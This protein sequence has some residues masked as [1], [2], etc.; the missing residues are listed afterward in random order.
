VGDS[1]NPIVDAIRRTQGI[2]WVHVHNEEAGAFAACAEAQLTGRLAV[3]AGSAGP[4]NT[5]L[6]Q[7][8]YDASQTRAPVLALASHVPT[9]Q[10]GTSFF[11]ETRPGLLFSD[12]SVWLHTL[13]SA[14]QMPRMLRVA[15]Q[16][17]I[18]KQAVWVLVVPGNVADL[19]AAHPIG[20]GVFCLERGRVMPPPS[21]VQRLA[22]AI[23]AAETIL[24]FCGAGVRGA[25]REVMELAGT[26]HAPVG[27]SLRGT[28]AP[29]RS[30]P[31]ASGSPPPEWPPNPGRGARAP[32]CP[33]A[34]RAPTMTATPASAHGDGAAPSPAP[35]WASRV[36]FGQL[37]AALARRDEAGLCGEHRRQARDRQAEGVDEIPGVGV[38]RD[39]APLSCRARLSSGNRCRID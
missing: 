27:H 16:E 28:A 34:H 38:L 6:I 2:E 20:Q 21:Q 33:S 37:R 31:P 19:A 11:Q 24:L 32:R 22:D 8:L 7:G 13:S 23:N 35:P 30:R 14:D 3:C 4:G 9:Y 10:V 5:H 1:L 36:A 39:R 18:A 29:A 12:V 15:I 17:A 26:V 25:H